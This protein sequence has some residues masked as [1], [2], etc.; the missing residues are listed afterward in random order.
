M[1]KIFRAPRATTAARPRVPALLVALVFVAIL[2]ANTWHVL[3]TAHADTTP[4][5]LPFTQDWSNAGLITTN[6]NWS[7]VPGIIAYR[8]DDFGTGVATTTS[9]VD[10]QT[11]TADMSGTPVNVIANQSSP[12][13]LTTGGVA[14]FDG[15]ANPVVALQGSGTADAPNVVITINTTGQSNINIAYNLRD[16]D[17]SADNAIQPVALQYRVGNSGSYTNV[18]AGFVS[19]ASSGPS[20]A[21]LV[22]P[23]S[24]TLPAAVN[25]QPVVQIRILTTN[26]VG[27]DEWIGIDDINITS[28][29]GG[30][31]TNP[32][33]NGASNPSTVVPGGSSLL[34]VNVLPGANPTS[35]GL[36]VTAN[37]TSIGGS[38]S[39]TFF[40]DGSNGDDT[41]GDNIF[42]FQASIPGNTSL[43]LKTM[44]FTI[45]DAQARSGGGNITLTVQS[46]S[47]VTPIDAIQGPT[48][49]TPNCVTLSPLNGQVVTTQGVVTARKSNGFFIQ[50]PDASVDSDPTSSEGIFVFTSSA[51]PAAAA[52]NNLVNVTATVSEFRPSTDPNS[53]PETELTG[54]TVA[55]VST[56][57][58]LPAAI[59]LT[60]TD[61][62]PTGGF[63][64][65]E[66]YEGMRVH[67]DSLTVSGPT[68]GSVDEPNAR[69][70]SFGTFYG[71]LT[72]TPRPFVE[73]GIRVPD[74]VPTPAP[75]GTPP[76]NVPRFDTNPEHIRIS[77]L[78]QPGASDLE[79]SNGAVVTNI[80]G[81]LDYQ[82]RS[83]MID[84]D[85][86]PTP[87][88]TPGVAAA[89]P[90]PTPTANEFTVASFNMQRFFDTTDDP[91]TSDAV[92]CSPG[93]PRPTCT[94]P[95][96]LND[97]LNKA[98]LAIRNVMQTPD[99]VGVE[100]M[101]NLTN[102]QAVASKVNSDAIAAAQPN[103]NY[104][105]YL[106]EGNDIGGI[107]V[108]FLVK[109]S[110]VAVVDV[111]QFGKATTWVEPG[112]ATSLLN[113]RPPLVLRANITRP[114]TSLQPVTVIVVHQRSLSGIDGTDATRIR[115]KRQAQAEYLA[116]LIQ[117]RQIADPTE[118][119][120]SVGDYNA[121][122]FND[123]YVDVIG[124]VKGTPTP[125]DQVVLASTDR[126]NPDLTDLIETLSPSARYS[127]TFDGNS[128]SIDHEL[129]NGN[130]AR[131]FSRFAV[132][133]MDA[134]FPDSLR[135]DPNRPERIS[136]H[137][138]E[139][140]FFDLTAT[141]RSKTRAD[142]TGDRATDVSIFRTSDGVWSVLDNSANVIASRKWGASTDMLVPG[143]YD[144][145][146][147]T[148]FAV[149]RPSEANWYIVSSITGNTSARTWGAV[150]D[151]PVP[152]DYDRDNKTDLAVFRPS[153]GNWYILNSSGG[154]ITVRSWGAS[155]DTPAPGDYDGDGKTDVAVWRP[156]EGNWY[157]IKSSNGT[158]MTQS[159][160]AGS[161][162]D[163]LVQADY[164]GDGKTD[165]AV[166]R[167]SQGN[168][169]ILNSSNGTMTVR[170]WGTSSDKLVPGDYDGDGKADVAIYRPSEGNWYVIRSSNGAVSVFNSGA[171][172]DVPVPQF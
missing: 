159:W 9:G 142:F 88:V 152:G 26:A 131:L 79:V 55:I 101:E 33:G 28:G 123:G 171:L 165:L 76:A 58:P 149:W 70:T 13:T 105:A 82:F 94:N 3:P 156:S 130:A 69:S 110:R 75:S 17:G 44:P 11:I 112:G 89:I 45:N 124:T 2:I 35:T 119:I 80:T 16:I 145:D 97:R 6:D 5:S 57:N 148:D 102:L 169:Y 67:V 30:G 150:G 100:E 154:S 74:P 21:T 59:T 170:G 81:P 10:P 25:N 73:P 153:E 56:S 155:T 15:I 87:G 43:G 86:S 48:C 38:A 20:L 161:A 65:L 68:E 108:G 160:G 85:P 71:V 53:P 46:A 50:T 41:A 37:L 134:D 116:D 129:I 72:G 84:I 147:K 111:T 136:D 14:E 18:P 36:T 78:A 7:G 135:N 60:A 115:A 8:G 106:V 144:G 167:P 49:A 117:A 4:Q 143:D 62:S 93:D 114:D 29:G 83:Y 40:D 113:D 27:S 32:S 140:G 61:L 12:N 120:I 42:S 109:S 90:V 39:Q 51:P 122:Q 166:F 172:G 96:A 63:E 54:A 19:D 132:A 125:A 64:N 66:K 22:T 162:G 146:F 104:Q 151:V 91:G 23:I 127:Y 47:G 92:L 98:S 138:P 52:L 1:N 141:P 164:D 103:P 133:H 158:V 34:T 99:I 121:F 137:D 24:I 163:Q 139:V 118:N 168:W 107:D 157:I 126:V 31:P 128:Q 77:S 95:N